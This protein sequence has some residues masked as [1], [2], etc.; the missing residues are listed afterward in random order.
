MT[1]GAAATSIEI[2][3]LVKRFG[4]STA[5]AGI[6]LAIRRGEFV[7]VMGPSGCGKTTTL[8]MIAGLETPDGGDILIDGKRVNHLKPWQRETPLVWQNF[9]LFPHL[10][11]IENVEYGLRTR[12][13]PAAERRV[14]A[15]KILETVGLSGF[16]DRDVTRLSGGQKQRV[17]LARALVLDPKILLLDEPLGALDAKIGRQMQQE[18]RRLHQILGITFVYV[19]HNQV[20]A[21]SLAD[22]IVIMNGGSIVQVGTPQELFRKPRTRFVA[23]FVGANNVLSGKVQSVAGG[24]LTIATACGDFRVPAADGRSFRVEDAATFVVAADH[25]QPGSASPAAANAV[26]GRLTGIEMMGSQVSLYFAAA[27]GQELQAHLPAMLYD[28]LRFEIGADVNFHWET[29]RGHLL[30]EG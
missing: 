18:L 4:K 21:M 27:G 17:G 28:Q 14:R 19:T 26:S 8:R 2:R 5:V 10:T 7:V 23:E 3:G 16:E 24:E 1:A 25:L 9:A 29:S 13:V 30:A 15:L 22:R 12:Q 20:E 6:D 11:L